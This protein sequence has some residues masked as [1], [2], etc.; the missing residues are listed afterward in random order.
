MLCREVLRLR[1]RITVEKTSF[2]LDGKT[3]MPDLYFYRKPEETVKDEA[4][5]E[6]KKKKKEKEDAQLRL[7]IEDDVQIAPAKEYHFTEVNVG[8]WAAYENPEM[9]GEAEGWG[10]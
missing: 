7:A 10:N 2:I 6:S 3:I 5:E 9:E 4:D 8:Q 1:A